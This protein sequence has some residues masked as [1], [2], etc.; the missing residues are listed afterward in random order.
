[1]HVGVGAVRVR[2]C[3]RLRSVRAR[4][5]SCVRVFLCWFVCLFGSRAC[6]GVPVQNSDALSSAFRGDAPRDVSLVTVPGSGGQH[7]QVGMRIDL[8]Y[9]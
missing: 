3:L 8:C 5:S 4:V 7:I 9:W 2:A 6:C 1:M